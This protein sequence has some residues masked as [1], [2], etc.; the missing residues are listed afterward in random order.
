MILSDTHST[1]L[2]WYIT[3]VYVL[4]WWAYAM[5]LYLLFGAVAL[6]I[7]Q[8]IAPGDPSLDPMMIVF[9]VG[10]PLIILLLSAYVALRTSGWI[11]GFTDTLPLSSPEAEN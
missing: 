6:R 3:H 2:D 10:W 1:M 4:P 7:V 8:M 5:P 11:L 9:V